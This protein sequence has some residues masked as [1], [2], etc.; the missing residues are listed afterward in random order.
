MIVCPIVQSSILYKKE[1]SEMKKAL[2]TLALATAVTGVGMFTSTASADINWDNAYH[3]TGNIAIPDN[4]PGGAFAEIFVPESGA[5]SEIMV[6]INVTHTW[7]GDLRIWLRHVDSGN[8]IY[9]INRAGVWPGVSTFGYST[10]NFGN[11]ATGEQML[12]NDAG[13]GTYNRAERGGIQGTA[14]VNNVVGKWLADDAPFDGFG[15]GNM[16]SMFNGQDKH[17]TWQLWA[18]DFAGG[19]LGAIREFSLYFGKAAPA[20]SALALLGMAGVVGVRRR[21]N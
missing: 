16:L 6:G 15:G 3:W 13:A 4:S 8:E 2:G 18:A 5:I 12:F 21:R 11:L 10:D 14:G 17:G 20:P 1:G 19:D 9:L 7:Q